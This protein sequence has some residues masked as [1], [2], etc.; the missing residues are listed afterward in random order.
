[1]FIEQNGKLFQK[2]DPPNNFKTSVLFEDITNVK[3]KQAKINKLTTELNDYTFDYENEYSFK[4][5][6]IRY[7]DTSYL[8]I[9]VIDHIISDIFSIRIV[10]EELFL[11]Y[12]AYRSG[13]SNPL[14]PNKLQFKVLL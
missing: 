4:C 12:E 2:I 5:K 11:I 14:E 3:D 9:L 1:M 7:E 13:K 10:E 6:L 8:V